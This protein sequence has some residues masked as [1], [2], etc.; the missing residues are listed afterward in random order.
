[1]KHG[2]SWWIGAAAAAIAPSAWAGE[3]VTLRVATFNVRDVR[4]ADLLNPDQPRVRRI[5]EVIQRLR[6]TVILIN[7]IA[8]DIPGGGGAT[9]EPGQNGTRLVENFLAVSQGPGLE[10]LRY[11]AFMAPVNSG[12]ASGFDLNRDGKVADDYPRSGRPDNSGNPPAPTDEGRAYSGDCW[13]PG[14]FP[15]QLG[16]ALLV[17]ERLT[18]RTEKIRT[19]RLLPWDYM[20]G[21]FI[22]P[23]KGEAESAGRW[24]TDEELKVARLTSVGHWDV[25][26]ELPG[27]TVVHFLCSNPIAPM[28]DGPEKRSARRNHDEIRFWAD[29]IQGEPYIVDDRNQPG[30]LD[31]RDLF[32]IL[33]DLNAD[34]DKG[35]AYK[36]PIRNGLFA[37]RRI[38]SK[39]TPAS[40]VAVQGVGPEATCALGYRLDYVIPCRELAVGASGVWRLLPNSAGAAEFPSDHWP[41]W[42]ELRVP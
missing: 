26:V 22:P 12:M 31:G 32:V 11:K 33:G 30:G 36:S 10:P 23:A 24:Y 40:D 15:G 38:N 41:V 28:V 18:I 20:P 42:M 29:Y 35:G 6:P 21:A 34:P 25:P 3:P 39:A 4:T 5:A 9:G 19:F 1:M 14:E 17:D 2:R 13:G 37:S 7:E 8:Y 27:G 16:M